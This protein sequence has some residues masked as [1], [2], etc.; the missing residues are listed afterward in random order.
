[1]VKLF[2]IKVY[3]ILPIL[4]HFLGNFFIPYLTILSLENSTLGLNFPEKEMKNEKRIHVKA[5]V[6]AICQL[7]LDIIILQKVKL[8]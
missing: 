5:K 1:M 4:H 3:L 8:A 7:L 6:F 2:L